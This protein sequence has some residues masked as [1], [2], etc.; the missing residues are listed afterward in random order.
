M[1]QKFAWQGGGKKEKK[2][3]R[4]NSPK[5]IVCSVPLKYSEIIE[6]FPVYKYIIKKKSS[7]YG[8]SSLL[9][10]CA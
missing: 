5:Q 4:Q 8:S 7:T 1:D 6:I 2:A 10:K 9:L 3:K